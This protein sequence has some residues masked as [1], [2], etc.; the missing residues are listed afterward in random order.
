MPSPK[1]DPLWR[2][3]NYGAEHAVCS[4]EKTVLYKTRWELGSIPYLLF[5]GDGHAFLAP[6]KLIILF[7]TRTWQFTQLPTTKSLTTGTI[8]SLTVTQVYFQNL[9][10]GS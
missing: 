3:G 1:T 5:V 7:G 8:A 4:P 2:L 10:Q 9:V 6:P